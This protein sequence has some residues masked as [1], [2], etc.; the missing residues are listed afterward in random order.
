MKYADGEMERLGEL[1]ATHI[2]SKLAGL[3]TCL[4]AIESFQASI[5]ATIQ[6]W[7]IRSSVNFFSY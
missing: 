7:Y 1:S 5:C 2:C 3:P 4:V 6:G